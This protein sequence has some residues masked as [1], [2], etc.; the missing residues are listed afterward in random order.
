MESAIRGRHS[1]G[2]ALRRSSPARVG[3]VTPILS[4]QAGATAK[5][6]IVDS[7]LAGDATLCTLEVRMT[8]QQ[9]S[10]EPNQAEMKVAAPPFPPRAEPNGN[11][12]PVERPVFS[13]K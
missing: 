6:Q 10:G 2:A 8:T 9:V 13:E 1:A 5:R 7:F 11:R 12:I 3:L 4:Q